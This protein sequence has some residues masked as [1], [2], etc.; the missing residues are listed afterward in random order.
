MSLRHCPRCATPQITDCVDGCR[1]PSED[2]SDDGDVPETDCTSSACPRDEAV[3]WAQ[4]GRGPS[5]SAAHTTGEFPTRGQTTVQ[6]ANWQHF[7]CPFILVKIVQNSP[8]HRPRLN[9]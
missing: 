4:P 1:L 2:W 5:K 9:T 8:F 3:F 7:S 6:C